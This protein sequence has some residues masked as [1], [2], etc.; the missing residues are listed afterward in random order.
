MEPT[1]TLAL[2]LVATSVLSVLAALM[3]ASALGQPRRP[4]PG[5]GI[6]R[7]A[8]F[9]IADG[10]VVD[11]NDSG[12]R[13]LATLRDQQTG[14]EDHGCTQAGPA[15]S[16]HRLMK[17]LASAFPDLG[18]RIAEAARTDAWT[19]KANDNSGLEVRGTIVDGAL[20]LSLLSD[21]PS[22]VGATAD[23]TVLLDGLSWQA[24]N[25]ELRLLRRTNDAAPTPAWR[26]RADGQVV[27]AN[28]AYLRL[29]AETG[30]EGT[31]SWPLP[32][33]FPGRNGQGGRH[34][35]M[36][37]MGGRRRWFDLTAV[38]EG[39]ETLIFALAADDAQQ[40]ERAR[41]EF[42][43]TLTKTFASLPVGLAV[44]D[45]TRRLQLFNPALTDL[46]Q[47]EPEFLASRP[48]MEGFLN[49]MR[50]KRILPEPR[51]YRAWSRR[52]LDVE[53]AASG[54]AFEETWAL[55]DG[56]SFRVSAAPHP[57]GALALLIEDVTSDI[58]LKR[59]FRTEL[60]IGRAAMDMVETAIGVFS[61]SG[62]LVMTNAAFD[63]LWT[64][65]GADTLSGV[66]LADAIA[67]WR[68]VAEESGG[69][70]DLWDRIAMLSQP[71]SGVM[72]ACGVIVLPDGETL[73]VEARVAPGGGILLGFCPVGA[74]PPL[75]TLI[76]PVMPTLRR[77]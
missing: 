5:T 21:A 72:R 52:L 39:P 10:L 44:F 76:D 8:V 60:D 65:E 38:P 29:L 57:D 32:N 59:S 48:G 25:D 19:L 61:N 36:V 11:A 7:D 50:D 24:L 67:N 71:G 47:L 66:Q 28:G 15:A 74:L 40:A 53:A 1:L 17:H 23:A 30:V 69:D 22:S 46:T 27:W 58:H 3:I 42:V 4:E 43:Q 14:G 20:R 77:A 13:L 70:T 51:D 62:D 34:S 73:R 56:R 16:L 45:R 54:S 31:S 41:R 9:L 37:G 12:T 49:R 33:L 75:T 63:R 64:L 35:V 55:P 68:E 18:S 26:E 2:I 6:S